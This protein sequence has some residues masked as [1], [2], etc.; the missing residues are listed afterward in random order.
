MS[1]QVVGATILALA[2]ATPAAATCR[3]VPDHIEALQG[4]LPPGYP[5]REISSSVMPAILAWMESEGMATFGAGRLVQVLR[6]DGITLIPVRDRIC[7]GAPAYVLSPVQSVALVALV[8][9]YRILKGW[10]EERE[11]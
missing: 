11:A 7:D 10:G 8:R 6:P 3:T 2:L 1:A 9:R 4:V 5:V